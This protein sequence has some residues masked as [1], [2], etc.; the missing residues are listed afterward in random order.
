LRQ[1]RS[2]V[3][4]PNLR[5]IITSITADELKFTNPRTSAGL[6][7]ELVFKRAK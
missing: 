4:A 3:G 7:L 1:D 6:T 2:L 5:R